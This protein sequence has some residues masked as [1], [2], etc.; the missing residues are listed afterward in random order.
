MLNKM[1]EIGRLV[2]DPELRY[3]SSG[4]AVTNVTIAVERPRGDKTDF[5]DV[6]VWNKRAEAL[7]EYKEK[8][9]WIYVEGY[10]QIRK[11][12]KNGRTYKNPELVAQNV[13]YMPMPSEQKKKKKKEVET[14][15][16]VKENVEKYQEEFREDNKVPGGE[17]EDFDVPF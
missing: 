2:A 13:K 14:E 8:G 17:D 7:C 1:M 12:E 11:N 16:E 6:V 9:D 3:T 5:I 15:K 4:K 10:F